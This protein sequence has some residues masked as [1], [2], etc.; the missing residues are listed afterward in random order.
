MA[1]KDK[2]LKLNRVK[3]EPTIS[4]FNQYASK[5]MK[6]REKKIQKADVTSKKIREAK[7]ENKMVRVAAGSKK[8]TKFSLLDD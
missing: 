8:A 6:S 5:L 2:N 7:R 3:K 4:K 1:K